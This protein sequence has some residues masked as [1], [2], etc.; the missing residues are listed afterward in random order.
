FASSIEPDELPVIG[1]SANPDEARDFERQ[2]REREAARD[3]FL[4]KTRDEYLVDIRARFDAYLRAAFDIGFNGR[5]TRL[6]ER[7]KADQ[8][9]P[10]RP[11]ALPSRGQDS[12]TTPRPPHAPLPAPGHAFAALSASESATRARE[13]PRPLPKQEPRAPPLAARSFADKP[14]AT[15]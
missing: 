7:S 5:S 3:T 9:N 1:P 10:P 13:I 4:V 12:L 15:M 14:P 2:F 8:L 6:D 11:R